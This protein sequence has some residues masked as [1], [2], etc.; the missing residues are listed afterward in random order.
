LLNRQNLAVSK[1]LRKILKNR[2]S[3]L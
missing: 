1:W 2:A 3:A